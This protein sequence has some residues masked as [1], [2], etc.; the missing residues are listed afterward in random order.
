[1]SG[2]II[3]RRFFVSGRVQG[4]FFRESTA[5]EARRLGVSGTAVNLHDGRVEVLAAGPEKAMD[6]LAVWLAHGPQWARVDR[7]DTVVEDLK[8]IDVPEGFRTG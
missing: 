4:V 2:E 1:M 8:T 6:E 7:V 5:R 3:C